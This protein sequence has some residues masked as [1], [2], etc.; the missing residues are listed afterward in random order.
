MVDLDIKC[1]MR[2][3][4]DESQDRNNWMESILRFL[5]DEFINLRDNR[6]YKEDRLTGM[7]VWKLT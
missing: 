7:D 5:Y 2:I 3:N 4:T 1:D 6:L